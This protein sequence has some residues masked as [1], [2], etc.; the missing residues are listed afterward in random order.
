MAIL[1]GTTAAGETLPILVNE[2]GSPLA[3]GLQGPPGEPGEQ[4]PPGADGPPGPPGPPIN[5]PPD[6]WEGALL[7]WL[8][9]ELAWIGTPPTPVPPGTYGP[10]VAWDQATGLMELEGEFDLIAG[11]YITQVD[12]TGTPTSYWNMEAEW[13]AGTATG[14]Y[15][16]GTWANVFDGTMSE[17]TQGGSDPNTYSQFLTLDNPI[18][19]GGQTI[20]YFAGGAQNQGG[21]RL[22][23]VSQFLVNV[24]GWT[25]VTG[26]SDEFITNLQAMP[27]GGSTF[28]LKQ[29][30]VG[31]KLLVNGPA[32]NSHI[33]SQYMDISD[34]YGGQVPAN[35]FNGKTSGDGWGAPVGVT[36]TWTPPEIDCSQ[37]RIY[38]NNDAG[39]T[40]NYVINGTQNI[41]A[42]VGTT[43]QWTSPLSVTGGKL[44]SIQ[45]PVR[46]S[47]SQGYTVW[48][49]EADGVILTDLT[50][51][52]GR[53]NQVS[54]QNLLL[55]PDNTFNI[56]Q[57]VKSDE[58]LAARWVL[59]AYER[60]ANS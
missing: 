47:G 44:Q 6:P 13:S 3:T 60:K 20:E 14:D 11:Q 27:G 59:E 24:N 36:A 32:N 5:L 33:W 9:G 46:A 57:R 16:N 39:L 35:A 56:G 23:N 21:L 48:A 58:V 2:A 53:I 19:V 29:I 42:S 17:M 34:G 37:L 8:G 55:V 50:P 49:I 38:C 45:F 30:R 54:G 4:G 31:G 52:K 25:T 26:F 12:N 41:S 18:P 15:P 40:G 28:Q 10:I 22:N 51:Q 43:P 1:Y 7:G